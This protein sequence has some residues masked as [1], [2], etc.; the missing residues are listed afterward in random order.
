MSCRI[1]ISNIAAKF[2]VR[3]EKVV[4][5]LFRYTE[6]VAQ[7]PNKDIQPECPINT[8]ILHQ[9]TSD[10]ATNTA[11]TTT[12][13]TISPS[14]VPPWSHLTSTDKG[15]Q[16][17]SNTD[18]RCPCYTSITHGHTRPRWHCN[19]YTCSKRPVAP[20]SRHTGRQSREPDPYPTKVCA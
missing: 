1:S 9:T 15:P 6:T 19:G 5:D 3:G 4:T 14:N 13:T 16:Q 17:T 20:S 7:T 11:D 10:M 2:F 12:D 18:P 8:G